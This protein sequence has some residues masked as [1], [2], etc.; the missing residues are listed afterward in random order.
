M[1]LTQLKISKPI[2]K[3]MRYGLILVL[4]LATFPAVVLAAPPSPLNPASPAARSIANLHNISLVIATLV[5]ITVCTLLIYALIRYRRRSDDE[6]PIQTRYNLPLE[7]FYTIAP[8]VMVIVF[9]AHTVR[10]QD[11]VLKDDTAPDNIV[12]V[13][14]QQWSWTFN[15]GLGD[16]DLGRVERGQRDG[17]ARH[18][19]VHLRRVAEQHVARQVDRALAELPVV[20]HE[21][22]LVGRRAV[23]AGVVGEGE[24]QFGPSLGDV[25]ANKA[26]GLAG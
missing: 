4:A 9:F 21:A 12:E 5:F 25:V 7:I 26:L 16:V 18:V 11:L 17:H 23:R 22:L 24:K 20:D 3:L 10:T 8:V 6:I 2:L 14:G 13:T 19:A 1:N 15:Y